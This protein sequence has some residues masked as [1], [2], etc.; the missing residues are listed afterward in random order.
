MNEHSF[1][2][3]GTAGGT[4]TIILAN[5]TSEDLLQTTVLAALG[6]AVSFF[7]SFFLKRIMKKRK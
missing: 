5:I 4:L 2:R 1:S 7:V 6:A 3:T